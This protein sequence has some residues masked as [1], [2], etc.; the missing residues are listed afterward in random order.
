MI[1]A[2][3]RE[4]LLKDRTPVIAQLEP[5]G[6]GS[7][8]ATREWVTVQNKHVRDSGQLVEV[9]SY[10]NALSLEEAKEKYPEYMI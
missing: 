1:V 8:I 5:V 6:E 7:N 2:L 9:I 10:L 4:R 3:I